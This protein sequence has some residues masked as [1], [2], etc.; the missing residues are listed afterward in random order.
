VATLQDLDPSL[1][2]AL[3]ATLLRLTLAGFWIIHRWFKVGHRGMAATQ[4]FFLQHGLPPWLAWF[5]IGFELVVADCLVLGICVRLVCLISLPILFAST[6][7]YRR[8]GFYFSDGASN[9]RHYGFA[10]RSPRHFSALV[11]FGLHF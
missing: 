8:N 5:V 11:L 4:A 9:F 6:W 7:I 1:M 2:S 10:Y 3:G